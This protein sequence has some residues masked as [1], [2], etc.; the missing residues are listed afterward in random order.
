[1][2]RRHALG[3][4]LEHVVGDGG[5]VLPAVPS[6]L[7]PRRRGLSLLRRH[8]FLAIHHIHV[9]RFLARWRCACRCRSGR[10]GCV[11]APMRWWV[12]VHEH[13][14]LATSSRF[15]STRLLLPASTSPLIFVARL[16]IPP[17]SRLGG[18]Q[19]TRGNTMGRGA[20]SG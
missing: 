13:M 15:S 4:L 3:A 11:R 5:E 17:R 14:Q 20:A 19:V 1:M 7:A 16:P 6:R 8:H 2:E 10:G 9:H 12:R 18:K